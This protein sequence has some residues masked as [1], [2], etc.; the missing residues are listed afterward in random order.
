LRINFRSERF[1]SN[2]QILQNFFDYKMLVLRNKLE[3]ST[4]TKVPTTSHLIKTQGA[5]THAKAV[6]RSWLDTSTRAYYS[7]L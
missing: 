2:R 6:P 4:L 7:E 3:R 1:I 5:L